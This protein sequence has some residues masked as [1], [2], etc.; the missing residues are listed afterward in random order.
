MQNSINK[1][2][3]KMAIF[4]VVKWLNCF[5][6]FMESQ[7]YKTVVRPKVRDIFSS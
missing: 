4:V 5:Y 1:V 6:L 3:I 2:C 7:E